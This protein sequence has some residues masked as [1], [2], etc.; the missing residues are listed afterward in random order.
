MGPVMA[1]PYFV[2]LHNFIA[3]PVVQI[4]TCRQV[5]IFLREPVLGRVACLLILVPIKQYFYVD[6]LHNIDIER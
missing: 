4:E 3:A 2:Q 5:T 6:A 1:C